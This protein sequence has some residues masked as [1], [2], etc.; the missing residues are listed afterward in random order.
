MMRTLRVAGAMLFAACATQIVAPGS[1]GSPAG[2]GQLSGFVRDSIGAPVRYL[3]ILVAGC[4]PGNTILGVG[5]TTLG[6]MFSVGDTLPPMGNM[7]PGFLADTLHVVCNVSAGPVD[8]ER[9][10]DTA[11]VRYTT[12][13]PDW[14]AT[15]T[16]IFVWQP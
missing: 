15:P 8:S 6:G 4:T 5:E 3:R 13:V 2:Y 7:P 11:S 10:L 14:S 9:F 16:R 12:A 1:I